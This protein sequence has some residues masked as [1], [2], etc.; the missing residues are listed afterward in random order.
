MS[1]KKHTDGW[2]GFGLFVFSL[3]MYFLIIPNQIKEISFGAG[4]LSASFFP[5]VATVIIGFLSLVLMFNNF[6]LKQQT[7]INDFGP[8]A[9][10]II[11]FLIGYVAGVHVLGYLIATG[12]FLFTLMIYLSKEKWWRYILTI[13]VFLIVNYLFFEKVLNLILPRGILF[14]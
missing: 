6:I 10:N 11:L 3:V 7:R 8:K 9:L 14:T 1:K 13:T 5:R 12:L 4:S 2:I